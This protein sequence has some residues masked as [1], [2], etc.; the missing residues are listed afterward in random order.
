MH[1]EIS[2]E[3][4]LSAS[5]IELLR[6]LVFCLL[7]RALSKEKVYRHPVLVAEFLQKQFYLTSET[8]RK[9]I[10]E[11]RHCRNQDRQV[12]LVFPARVKTPYLKLMCVAEGYQKAEQS[13]AQCRR[14]I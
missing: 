13:T 2:E 8:H 9:L 3:R 7:L 14:L 10:E 4:T 12:D 6:T 5:T 11:T 1:F